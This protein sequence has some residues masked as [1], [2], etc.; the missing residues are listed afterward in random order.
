MTRVRV[1]SY[2]P[3]P[4]RQQ[5]LAY[6]G[7]LFGAASFLTVL[8]LQPQLVTQAGRQLTDLVREVPVASG[9]LHGTVLERLPHP[10]TPAPAPGPAS[11]PATPS[12]PA[13]S[14]PSA[15]TA[16]GHGAH[17]VGSSPA[18][19]GHAP[20]G[21]PSPPTSPVPGNGHTAG[22]ITGIIHPPVVIV[23]DGV[24][25]ATG[26]ASSPVTGPAV[27]VVDGAT[28]A[29]DGALGG[30]HGHGH[31][32]GHTKHGS[33]HESKHESKHSSKHEAKPEHKAGHAKHGKH[34]K[35]QH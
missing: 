21:H 29:L 17:F 13:T 6:G 27:Q 1:P 24:D 28:G 11:T 15:G 12:A 16:S 32:Y 33:K 19:G 20:G 2:R 23:A 3:K 7:V 35:R 31:A 34:A 26:G 4:T 18:T 5:R 25:Q 22:P 9:P 30:G 14:T 8:A 10:H